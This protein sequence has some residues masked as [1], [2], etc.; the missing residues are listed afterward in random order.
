VSG[1]LRQGRGRATMHRGYTDCIR[2]PFFAKVRPLR[3]GCRRMR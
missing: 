1:S 3:P 2:L